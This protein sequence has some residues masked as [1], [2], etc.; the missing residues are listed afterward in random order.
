[1][2][3]NCGGVY[4]LFPTNHVNIVVPLPDEEIDENAV[5][6]QRETVE[7]EAQVYKA[8]VLY[9]FKAETEADLN[10]QVFF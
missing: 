4:G 7:P 5:A 10:L 9:E 1:M 2:Y 3:G 8:Q 6:A